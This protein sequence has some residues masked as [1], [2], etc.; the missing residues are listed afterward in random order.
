[1][2]GELI[3]SDK[4]WLDIRRSAASLPMPFS[5]D[6]FLKECEVA[7]VLQVD[8][9]Q[10]KAKGIGVG[11]ELSLLREPANEH[12][13]EFSIRV[14]TSE[15]E[16]V[17]WIPKECNEILARLMDAGKLLVATVS[18]KEAVDYW[19]DMAVKVYLKEI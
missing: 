5:Q 18:R 16:T 19:L 9:V 1:M 6:I 2:D 15:K 14:Q 10:F 13:D 4:N 7:G 11:T 3:I 8:D 17:G 12:D